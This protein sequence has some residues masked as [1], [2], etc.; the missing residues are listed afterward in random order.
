L[1]GLLS[2]LEKFRKKSLRQPTEFAVE[3]KCER[4]ESMGADRS[5]VIR[6]HRGHDARVHRRRPRWERR[7]AS[8]QPRVD[9]APHFQRECALGRLIAA[10]GQNRQ[11]PIGRNDEGNPEERAAVILSNVDCNRTSGCQ[12]AGTFKSASILLRAAGD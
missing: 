4:R 5:R 2:R 9:L 6:D 1:A 11:I 8:R 12:P 7:V 3:R 10:A